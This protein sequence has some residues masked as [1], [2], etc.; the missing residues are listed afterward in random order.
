[1]PRQNV[2]ACRNRCSALWDSQ[3]A[4]GSIDIPIRRYARGGRT[5]ASQLITLSGGS[6]RA[7]AVRCLA[8]PT[9]P[10]LAANTHPWVPQLH[11]RLAKA[12]TDNGWPS[13]TTA[14]P[15]SPPRSKRTD[16]RTAADYAVLAK[17]AQPRT[18]TYPPEETS[19]VM[20]SVT[21]AFPS[22]PGAVTP[23]PCVLGRGRRR[24]SRRTCRG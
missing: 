9:S 17:V 8:K 1:M 4:I 23:W 2:S 6:A 14:D 19:Q 13:V 5:N 15:V 18:S 11:R 24:W 22:R 20:V 21:R 7:L 16:A 10:G 3:M 12:L